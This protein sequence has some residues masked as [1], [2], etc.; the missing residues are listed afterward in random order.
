MAAKGHEEDVDESRPRPDRDD[1]VLVLSNYIYSEV[2]LR[3]TQPG[4]NPASVGAH[5]AFPP[6]NNHL[7]SKRR[8]QTQSTGVSLLTVSIEPRGPWIAPPQVIPIIHV[9]G[10][11]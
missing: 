7:W 11:R 10:Q 2:G 3:L 1:D 9:Q 4:S 8:A 6:I 5:K